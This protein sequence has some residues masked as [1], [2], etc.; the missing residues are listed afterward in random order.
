MNRPS[1]TDEPFEGEGFNQSPNPLSA[2]LTT[3]QDLNGLTN[4]RELRDNDPRAISGSAQALED[5]IL[6][7]PNPT[8]D[9]L[10]AKAVTNDTAPVG[11]SPL[12]KGLKGEGLTLEV[13]A[14]VASPGG[15]SSSPDNGST[16]HKN[17]PWSSITQ[18]LMKFSQFIGPGFMIAVAYSQFFLSQTLL[19]TTLNIAPLA[20]NLPST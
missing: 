2:D 7:N 1:R 3:N 12:V 13:S 6:F 20:F 9:G 19:H 8:G 4:L 16:H 15:G 11:R 5:D 17:S 10:D 14:A 18:R